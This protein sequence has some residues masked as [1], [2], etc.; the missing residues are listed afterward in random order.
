MGQEAERSRRRTRRDEEEGGEEEDAEAPDQIKF[1]AL[2]GNLLAEFQAVDSNGGDT[3]IAVASV[4]V[5]SLVNY[6]IV[7]KILIFGFVVS[8]VRYHHSSYV[9]DYV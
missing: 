6:I 2:M 8:L 7:S 5:I 9:Y 3:V 4:S 1:D